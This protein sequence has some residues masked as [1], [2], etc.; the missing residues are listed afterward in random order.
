MIIYK[1]KIFLLILI[2]ITPICILWVKGIDKNKDIKS[3]D[4]EFP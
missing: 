1:I 3:D 4:V 2:A